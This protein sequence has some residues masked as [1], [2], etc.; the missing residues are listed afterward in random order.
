[1]AD[2]DSMEE[3]Q[4]S[5]MAAKRAVDATI[6][7]LMEDFARQEAPLAFSQRCVLGA[8]V[9]GAANMLRIMGGGDQKIFADNLSLVV[10][11]MTIIHD[12]PATPPAGSVMVLTTQDK[13]KMT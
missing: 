9:G 8:L 13:D 5:G 7:S 1:M 3:I 4:R 6:V 10:R 12:S 2:T 11:A